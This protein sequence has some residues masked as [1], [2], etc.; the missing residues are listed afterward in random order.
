M[1]A[2]QIEELARRAE[3]AGGRTLQVRV[4]PDRGGVGSSARGRWELFIPGHRIATKNEL[5]KDGC[6]MR[7]ARLKRIDRELIAIYA[8]KAGVP[9]ATGKRRFSMVVTMA[10]RMKEVDPDALWLSALDGAVAAR[11]LVDDSPRFVELGPVVQVK[12]AEKSTRIILEDVG[13]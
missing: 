1:D 9:A 11:L 12:G 8:A 2:K 4:E 10:G 13:S 6:H 5:T 7:A 3:A